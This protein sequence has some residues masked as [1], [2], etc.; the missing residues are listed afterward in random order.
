[1]AGKGE[2]WV[3]VGTYTTGESQGIY[4]LR[5]EPASGALAHAGIRRGVANPSFVAIEPQQRFL[6]AVSEMAGSGGQLQGAV[7]A[8]AIDG[9]TGG[10]TLLNE[11]PSQGAGPCHVSVAGGGRYV[12]V[13][14]YVSGSVAMFPVQDTGGLGLASDVVQHHGAGVNPERQEAPHAHS[15]TVDLNSQHALVAD[16]GLDRVM[17][18]QLDLKHGKLIPNHVPWIEVAAGSGPRHLAFHPSGRHAYLI[19]ELNSTLTVF[20]YDGAAGTLTRLQTIPT[21]PDHFEGEN[22]CADVHVAP[23]GRYVY[24]SNRGHDSIVILEVDPTTG[25][26]ALVGHEPTGG[27]TPR[28]FAI[29]PGGRFL[30]AANQDTDRIVTF[31]VDQSTGELTPTGHV[32]EVPN[33]VCIAFGPAVTWH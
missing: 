15:V 8:F 32:A 5:F 25:I 13:A 20:S 7:S 23:S 1:M 28:N 6:Y 29:D 31:E 19:N 18:Y 9:G 4:T 16:L 12:L 24:G 2:V 3:Y 14:N 26:L 33:P 11:Q 22:W 21:L 17:V 10:L 27:R 30:L